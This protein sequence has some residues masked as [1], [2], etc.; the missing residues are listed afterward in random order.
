MPNSSNKA[1][2][3]LGKVALEKE[4]VSVVKM[5]TPYPLRKNT[6]KSTLK[7]LV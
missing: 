4:Q 7:N 5:L 3:K 2:D 1:K 6:T